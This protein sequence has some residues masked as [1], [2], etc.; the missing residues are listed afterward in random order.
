MKAG[1]TVYWKRSVIDL[2]LVWVV[3]ALLSL[4]SCAERDRRPSDA[5][6]RFRQCLLALENYRHD[7]GVF[8]VDQRGPNYALYKIKPYASEELFSRE[9][10]SHWDDEQQTIVGVEYVYANLELPNLERP[11]VVLVGPDTTND[12]FVFVGFSNGE[13]QMK[14]GVVGD[15]R[16]L[17]GKTREEL[18]EV[19]YH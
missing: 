6:R 2:H 19:Q 3:I 17:I 14:T 16:E 9:G 15:G 13:V 11:V 1:Y 10:N 8:P 18:S 4:I 12:G 7:H 5:W